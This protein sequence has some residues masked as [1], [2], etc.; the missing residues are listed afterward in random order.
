MGSL[1]LT[2]RPYTPRRLSDQRQQAGSAALY[3]L[4]ALLVLSAAL[5][6]LVFA[7]LGWSSLI[8]ADWI[9]PGY[10]TAQTF[11]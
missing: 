7:I 6:V 11:K 5:A 9:L 10:L 8:S 3:F 1:V 4:A 2:Q